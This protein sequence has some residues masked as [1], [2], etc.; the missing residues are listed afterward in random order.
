[1]IDEAGGERRRGHRHRARELPQPPHAEWP[2]RARGA[3]AEDV[4][5]HHL[6]RGAGSQLM[7][8]EVANAQG[9][10][11]LPS[12]QLQKRLLCYIQRQR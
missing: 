4:E 7:Q 8:R 5:R 3:A 2:L 10:Y 9:R 12:Q 6:R 11:K 1:M